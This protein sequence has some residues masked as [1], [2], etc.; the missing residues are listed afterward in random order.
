MADWLAARGV[1]VWVPEL[2]G[3][4][5]SHAPRFDW[6]LDEY[7]YYDL[8]AIL[9][10]VLEHSG[11]THVDWVGHSMGGILLMGY[12]A[13]HPEAPIARGV[14]IGSA[15]DYT[16]GGTDFERYMPLRP[17]LELLKVVPYGGLVHVISPI[18]GVPPRRIERFH[19]WPDNIEPAM[20]RRIYARCFHA[21][22][23]SLLVSLATTFEDEGLRLR[24]GEALLEAAPMFSAP[25]LMLA[26]DRDAQVSEAAIHAAAKLIGH[27]ARVMTFGPSHGH[28]HHYGHFDLI[29]GRN[30]PTE[31]WGHIADFL[32]E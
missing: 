14:T 12:G 6:R 2:R 13:L 15:L 25:L 11:A 28:A 27:N 7:L 29:L 26:G 30:A 23:T 10:A 22:P 18:T 20:V 16:V 31:V 5:T 3:H 8:P 19:V 21:I 32:R 24:K 9:D 1:D 4:G 17:L